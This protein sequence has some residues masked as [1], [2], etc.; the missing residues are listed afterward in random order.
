MNRSFQNQKQNDWV[1]QNQKPGYQSKID[2]T[3][4]EEDNYRRQLESRERN[5][6][7]QRP[8]ISPEL[9]TTQPQSY[10]RG[11]TNRNYDVRQPQT[12]KP[13][14]R[15]PIE[16]PSLKTE[17]S[18]YEI[19][20]VSSD[21]SIDEINKL[22][23]KLVISLHPDKGL[24]E[25]AIQMGWTVEEK[26][27]AFRD[28]RKAYQTILK[29]RKDSDC[30]DY[31]ID[32]YIDEEFS[33]AHRLDKMGL[34]PTDALPE[35]FNVKHFNQNFSAEQQ[36]HEQNGFSNPYER[37]YNE[38]GKSKEDFFRD[39]KIKMPTRADI[40]V[41]KNPVLERAQM[42]D[43]RLINYVPKDQE[44]FGL[45]APGVGYTEL[46][47]TTVEDF[48]MTMDCKGGICG[49]DL[50]SVYGQNNEN[51]EDSVARDQSLYAKYNDQTRP[52]K[53]MNRLHNDRKN[54]DFKDVDPEIQRQID[55]EKAAE[56]RMER[57]RRSFVSSQ[58]RYYDEFASRAL[59][60]VPNR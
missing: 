46:G 56:E 35:N 12:Q 60:N 43:G 50:M 1:H 48:S 20:G 19:L 17:T 31:N 6:D 54:F 49:S 51:W 39:D 32:Y 10:V 18:P 3:P 26:N 2:L 4:L 15:L 45:Q 29:T 53:K 34:N 57:M 42:K 11:V 36:F 58:D 30:P 59:R 23:K 41:T 33:Q 38:F 55:Q 47:I 25:E 8:I 5:H 52:E 27:Q 9:E 28:V 21:T 37:G 13:K 24:S 44:S 16:Y 14:K 22:Y 7:Y 40:E